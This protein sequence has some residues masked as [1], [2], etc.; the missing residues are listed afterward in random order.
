MTEIQRH[1]QALDRIMAEV[2]GCTLCEKELPLGPRPVVRG[3]AEAPILIVG[4]APGIKVHE[5]GLPWNDPSGDRLRE[6]L[7]VDRD[8]FYDESRFA[9]IPMGY[10]YPGRHPRGGDLPPRTECAEIW[11]PQLLAHLPRIQL[12]ILAGQYAQKHYLGSRAP[13]TLT[14]TVRAWR[15]YWPDYC[16]LPHPSFRNNHWIATHPWFSDQVIPALRERVRTLLSR[17]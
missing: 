14:A 1:Q 16:P 10:C 5:T 11:L 12:T 6:W 9:I 13:K 2:R 7:D 3:R 4:Q 15:E 8:C 17:V